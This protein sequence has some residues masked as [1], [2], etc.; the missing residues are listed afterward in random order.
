MLSRRSFLA[1]SATSAIGARLAQTEFPFYYCRRSRRLRARRRRQQARLHAEPRSSRRRRHPVRPPPLQFARLHAVAPIVLHRPDAQH[2][3]RHRAENARSPTTSRPSRSN[4]AAPAITPPSSARCISTSRRSPGCIGFEQLMLEI[5]HSE[6]VEGRGIR[7]RRPR[8]FAS[9]PPWKPFQDPARIWLNCRETALRM[10]LR[11]HAG[12]VPG[13]AGGAVSRAAQERRALRTVGELSGAALAVQLPDRRHDRFDA[14]QFPGARGRTGGRVA[15]PTDLSR[16]QS[17]QEKQ[18]IIASYYTSVAFLDRN[19]GVVLDALRRLESGARHA[20]GVHRRPRLRSGPAWPFREALLLRSGAARAVVDALAGPN[21]KGV[22]HDFTESIDVAP[23]ILD[24]LGVDRLPL[25]HGQSLRPYRGRREARRAA[26]SHLQPVS[27]ERGSVRAHRIATSSSCARASASATTA[28][29]PTSRRR[30]VIKD[31][32]SNVSNTTEKIN[33][34]VNKFQDDNKRVFE[35]NADTFRKNQEQINKT[36]QEISNNTI[37]L[38]KNVLNTYQSAYAQFWNNIN[39]NSYWENFNI[40]Q[41]Y[42]ET[43]NTLNKNI[44]NY[45]INTTNSIN[46]IIVGGI[47]NFNK[48]IELTQRYYNDIM[49]NNFNYARKIERSSAYNR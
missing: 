13:A 37:E 8:A 41:R 32:A 22:V 19:I 38:Q 4:C 45:T 39:N 1:G 2:G 46:E 18:G 27:G 43:Y 26:R 3:R 9:K 23:T 33:E 44:Q 36:I 29:R 7:S 40:P 47:E 20:G 10:L 25:Q 16:P 30:A 21:R 24:L 12:H 15:D 5:G 31:T 14:G 48:S 28:M 17:P 11:R 34:N 42:S 6:S 35:K 49:Q